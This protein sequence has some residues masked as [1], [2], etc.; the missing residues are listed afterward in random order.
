MNGT[1][2]ETVV[3]ISHSAVPQA[4]AIEKI[5]AEPAGRSAQ[6]GRALAH[7]GLVGGTRL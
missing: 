3:S 5:A 4:E 1:A 2:G 6:S 7:L